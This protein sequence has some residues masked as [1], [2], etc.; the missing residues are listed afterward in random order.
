MPAVA[1]GET[2][3]EDAVVPV[4]GE[5]LD[6]VL[7]AAELHLEHLGHVARGL[8]G[9]AGDQRR[10][11]RRLRHHHPPAVGEDGWDGAH[12]EDDA[13]HVVS[14]RRD[15]GHGV[16]RVRRRVE[17]RLER[18]GDDQ[19]D[20][21]TCEDAKPFHGKHGRDE[22][23]A[24]PLVGVL[25]NDGRGER[26]VSADADAE[27][28]PEEAERGHDAV[29]R[30]PERQA[31]EE[32]AH[33]HEHDGLAVELL[34]ADLVA[35][36]AKQELAH[37]HAAEGDAVD[38]RLDPAGEHPGLSLARDLVIDASEE[39]GDQ[40]DAEDVVGVGEEAHAG[41]HHRPRVVPL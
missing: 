8:L 6:L 31:G 10:I 20:N 24:R 23:P 18:G 13:P 36:P 21:A 4:L 1:A 7:L 30:V 32:G 17:A 9:V 41:D 27:P 33:D 40:G 15:R 3:G 25:G 2:A 29:G 39:L 16:F 14:L 5:A 35:E 26:I 22:A 37:D 12:H 11:A 38:G 28:E 34:P 19:G